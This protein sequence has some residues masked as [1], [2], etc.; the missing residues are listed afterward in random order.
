MLGAPLSSEQP[1]TDTY[2]VE[3]TKELFWKHVEEVPTHEEA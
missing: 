2:A 1:I 3:G